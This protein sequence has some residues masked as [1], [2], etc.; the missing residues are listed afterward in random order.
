MHPDMIRSKRTEPRLKV[1]QKQQQGRGHKAAH[2]HQFMYRIVVAQLFDDDILER[3]YEQSGAQ[4]EDAASVVVD[5]RPKYDIIKVVVE[6]DKF[7]DFGA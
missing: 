6:R 7:R 2:E 4:I 5:P 1:N 3:E